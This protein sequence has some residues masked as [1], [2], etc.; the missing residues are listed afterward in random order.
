MKSPVIS[1]LIILMGLFTA[2]SR[3]QAQ[4]P[5]GTAFTYQ[6]QLK[7]S[8][9]PVDGEYDFQF[10][11][12]DAPNGGSPVGGNV[13]PQTLP[14]ANGLFVAELDFEP[15]AF[16][17]E[18]RWLEIGVRATDVGGTFTTLSPR[19]AL[20]AA[21]YALYAL[22]IPSGAGGYWAAN[23]D[24]IHN[25]NTG[26]VG[27]G[28]TVPAAKLE[29]RADAGGD[30]LRVTAIGPVGARLDLKGLVPMP[31]GAGYLGIINFLNFDD[32][33]AGGLDY[34]Q[35]ET[36]APFHHRQD[37][38]R[39]RV[40]ETERMCI[41]VYDGSAR[42]TLETSLRVR[43]GSDASL[44]GG[45]YLV[46]GSN[47]AGNLAFDNNEI[48]ARDDGTASTLYLN[49]DG[50]DIC[51]AGG[52]QYGKVGIGTA[53]PGAR[54]EVQGNGSSTEPALL[55]KNDDGTGLEVRTFS[56]VNPAVY[57]KN[58]GND[59]GLEVYSTIHTA[60]RITNTGG[61]AL[62]VSG[63]S[64]GPAVEIQ[65]MGDGDGLKVWGGA[66]VEV[67]RITGAD[68]AEKFPTSE[69]VKPGMVLA[70]DPDHPGMLR[71]ARGAY[72]RC[73]AGVVSGAN[74]LPAGAVLGNLPGS[75]DAPAVALSGRVWVY[76]D[77]VNQ[78]IAPGDLL[79]T[80]TR[81][82]YAMKVVD[83]ELAQGAVLGKAMTALDEGTGLV[84]VLVSL[85]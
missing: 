38:L 27:V 14:V 33:V 29:V 31:T 72:D 64:L 23:G 65:Q 49:N 11:L 59:Y 36:E 26:K 37:E 16:N 9:V 13:T 67:L 62:H 68:V 28:T 39:L 21:P 12:Y 66:S 71:L 54:L 43:S 45:G 32:T 83:H 8:G 15:D 47:D 5:V 80:A 52:N 55:V 73:V 53:S 46:T 60:A 61:K 44:S 74:G 77:A 82:G 48:M 58:D 30:G 1:A 34:F 76:G 2:Q 81:S 51:L 20:T 41:G 35:L 3:L 42:T 69:E 50:G 6:G 18:G 4:V 24:D 10:R 17:G 22:D 84:L 79:T 56:Y 75:E 7:E 63:D 85:Q 19:Q 57:I 78:P 25:A 70:I 40:G